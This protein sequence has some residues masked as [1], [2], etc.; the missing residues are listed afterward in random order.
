M[1]LKQRLGLTLVEVLIAT[2]VLAIGALGL[3]ASSAAMARQ[4]TAS[5]HRSRGLG[6]ARSRNENVHAL[7]C[8]EATGSDRAP[9]VTGDWQTVVTGSRLTLIQTIRRYDSRGFH[10]DI[11]RSAA[12]CE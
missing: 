11:Y 5:G 1:T 6:I 4:I 9:G 3:A 2:L 12:P 10:T 7:P 8:A